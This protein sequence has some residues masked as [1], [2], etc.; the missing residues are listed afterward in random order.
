M[1]YMVMGTASATVSEQSSTFPLYS[2]VQQI[3]L[4]SGW[5]RMPAEKGEVPLSLDYPDITCGEG[6]H[7]ICS[8]GFKKQEEYQTLIVECVEGRL[9]VVGRY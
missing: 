8:V 5:Q 3:L 2:Q 1:L 6:T 4:S 7:A 9:Y